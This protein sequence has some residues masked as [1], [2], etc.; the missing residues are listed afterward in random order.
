MKNTMKRDPEEIFTGGVVMRL[1][2]YLLVLCMVTGL[3][4]I[5]LPNGVTSFA[6]HDEKNQVQQQG[7]AKKIPPPVD[8]VIPVPKIALVDIQIVQKKPGTYNWVRLSVENWKGYADA[9]FG[10]INKPLMPGCGNDPK[11]ALDNEPFQR[12][13]TQFYSENNKRLGDCAYGANTKDYFKGQ[14]FFLPKAEPLPKF[15]Y[16]LLTDSK[17]GKQ[18]KSNLV[19][20]SI[21]KP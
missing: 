15:V 10:L 6:N 16:L 17:T 3:L 20:L 2:K 12:L 14:S 9:L 13:V 19:S 7:P 1:N 21:Q 11:P 5:A 18:Y 8:Y 4:S